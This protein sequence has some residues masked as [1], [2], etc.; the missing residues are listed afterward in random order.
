MVPPLVADLPPVQAI[1]VICPP[2]WRGFTPGVS[3]VALQEVDLQVT[4][5]ATS[6]RTLTSPERANCLSQ[7]ASCLLRG[8]SR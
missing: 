1:K 4:P 2:S 5:L 7:L 3:L 6:V 8:A